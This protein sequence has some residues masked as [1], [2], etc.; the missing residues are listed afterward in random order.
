MQTTEVSNINPPIVLQML[1]NQ[2]IQ[3]HQGPQST[4]TS[5]STSTE[6]RSLGNSMAD[7]MRLANFRGDGSEDPDQ[8]RFLCEAIWNIKN[9]TDEVVKINQFSTMLRDCTLSWYMKLVQ[10][11][12]QPKPLN[13]IKKTLIKEFNKPNSESQ[14]IT[15]LKDIKQKVDE[16]IWEFDKR[17][18]TLVG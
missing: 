18:K 14:C 2:N 15:K 9:I 17:F 4:V 12:A 1:S 8:H 10:G 6:T 11:L 7:E 5:S 16:P 13:E 3:K